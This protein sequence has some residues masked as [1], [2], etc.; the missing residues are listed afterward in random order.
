MIYFEVLGQPF[1]VL[2]SLKR[3]NDLLEKRSSN[4]SDR[5]GMPMALDLMDWGFNF[6]FLPYG[7]W[8]R[9]HRRSFNEHF[10][11]NIVHKYHP[12]QSREV[13]EFLARLLV[14]PENFMHHIRHT[15]AAT[16]MSAA[17]DISV[18]LSE[19]PYICRAEES[20]AG[21]AAAGISGTFLVDFIP[22]LKYVPS[23]LPGA[24][25]KRKAAYWKKINHDLTEI[26]FKHVEDQMKAG[27]ASPS[28]SAALIEGLP[29]QN[30]AK[31]KEEREIA[32]DAAAIS[33]IAGADTTVSSV[34]SFFL[35]M[36]LYPEIQKKAQAEL[37]RVVG[38]HRLPD[39]SDRPEM[40]YINA[41]V[42][43]TSRWNL[44]LP[45]AIGHMVSDDDE[46]DG[47]FIPK[48]TVV[49]GNAW[50]IL[51][52]PTVY[53]NPSE[54]NPER[55]LNPGPNV[56]D[57]DCAAFGFGRRICPGRHMSDNSLFSIIASTLA[58]YDIK[59][60][61]DAKGNPVKPKPEFTTGLLTYP[62]PFKCT[63]TPRNRAAE[64]LI[65][66]SVSAT[67]ND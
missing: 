56:R 51:H 60:S 39:F 3:V 8:W 20:L 6:A 11:Q 21:I 42:K 28:I 24:S 7:S 9:R 55:Y 4:Y 29:P 17:Y 33:Y 27:K 18:K 15:F 1:L 5:V 61:V 48:G 62:V 54:Y 36:A 65:R 25:F 26:P 10:H 32:K 38:P 57:P 45:L 2:N 52:D 59:P 66:E 40:P 49:Y 64:D 53:T 14:T 67:H 16:I 22:A 44:V 35:A 46:Y 23:W 19:D 43:E 47:Y 34:Q 13:R 41:L 31:Y 58:V 30:D 12:V 50:A 37:D 63:I